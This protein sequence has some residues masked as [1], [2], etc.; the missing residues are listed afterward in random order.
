M[1]SFKK[2]PRTLSELTLDEK[3]GQMIVV[4]NWGGDVPGDYGI[5]DLK[6]GGV[7]PA[8]SPHEDIA[9][10]REDVRRMQALADIP[11][12]ICADFECGVGQLI[13]DGSCAEFPAL[14]AYG[15][16]ADIEEAERLAYESGR[17]AAMEAD[18]IGVNLTPSPVFDVNT[19]PENPISNTRSVGDDPERVWRI[20]GAYARGMQTGRLLPQAKHFPGEG[21][22]RFDPHLDLERMQ[23]TAEEMERVHLLPF[24]KAIEMGIP[25]M[26]T[27][28]AIYPCYD[29]EFPCTLS[30]KLITGLLRQQMGFD[31]MVITDAME[32]HGITSRWGSREALILAVNAGN[33]LILEP[34]DKR[35]AVE[36]IR[37]AVESGRISMET[38][39]RAVG[40][41]L[42]FKEHLRLYSELNPSDTPPSLPLAERW[43]VARE[44]A[45]KSITLIRDDQSILPVAPCSAMRVLLLEPA[46]PGHPEF[47]W[48]LK[49][50]IYSLS[51]CL[52]EFFEN[53]D[54]R[55]FGASTE[56]TQAD[57]IVALARQADM[58]FVSTSFKS[59]AGQVGLLNADQVALVR[60]VV[61]ANRRTVIVASNPYVAAELPFAETILVN[62]GP[63]RASVEAA[64]D[65][66]LGKT[67]PEGVLPVRLPESID[68]AHVPTIA[69]D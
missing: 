49:Y 55:Q 45:R 50:N 19:V 10:F 42:R 30:H 33:D 57:E 54:I 20:A 26:M 37:D 62:Y 38:I 44:V 60:G 11:L 9:A 16:I 28:H 22:H 29:D 35:F 61:S 40:R 53:A 46:N 17:I 34:T 52:K 5:T 41:I 4:A 43:A 51:D 31:G 3:I 32:M 69:H 36:W 1:D 66:I 2:Q 64:R 63:Y 8:G 58:V 27:N 48:G 59:R 23:V 13:S 39:D 15:A 21:M 12:F 25:M 7:W 47:D 14:M 56:R 24:R 18:Y 68:P 6:C 65:I 67:K